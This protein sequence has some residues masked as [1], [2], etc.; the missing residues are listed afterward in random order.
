MSKRDEL[1]DWA[2]GEI[3]P[4]RRA[5]YAKDAVGFDPGPKLAWCGFFCLAGLHAVGL[6]LEQKWNLGIGFIGPLG[7]KLTKTPSR[8]DIGYKAH[9]FQHHFLFDRE[10]DGWVY[11]IGGNTPDVKEQRFRKDEVVTYSI[12]PILPLP[13][14]AVDEPLPEAGFLRGQKYS[15]PGIEDK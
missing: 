4:G 1:L 13:I 12:E 2:K 15:V 6:A 5:D 11:G 9:P 10:H 3:G 7:L 8:G 14:R